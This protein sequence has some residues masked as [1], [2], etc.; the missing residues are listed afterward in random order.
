MKIKT[1]WLDSNFMA[2]VFLLFPPLPLV[3]LATMD[4]PYISAPIGRT[5]SIVEKNDKYFENFETI[6]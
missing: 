3:L 2:S 4:I 1:G 5:T 6:Y